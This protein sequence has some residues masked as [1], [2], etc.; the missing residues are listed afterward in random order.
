MIDIHVHI[1]PGVDDGPATIDQSMAMAQM[2]YDEGVRQ[3]IATPHRHHALQF[4]GESNIAEAYCEFKKELSKKYPDFEISLGCEF[5]IREGYISYID[6]PMASIAMGESDYVLME[7]DRQVTLAEVLESIYEFKIRNYKPIIAHVEMY[8]ALSSIESIRVLREKGATIQ[9]T[10]SSLLGKQGKETRHQIQSWIGSGLIDFVASDGHS[11]KK[12]RPLLKQAYEDVSQHFGDA[13]AQKLFMKNQE[14]L[15][16]NESISANPISKKHNYKI[17]PS[18]NLVA[19][20]LAVAIIGSVGLGMWYHQ[21]IALAKKEEQTASHSELNQKLETDIKQKL[22]QIEKEQK[23][24]TTEKA[25][26][27]QGSQHTSESGLISI[28]GQSPKALSPEA[29]D[30]KATTNNQAET[31][32]TKESIEAHYE[33]I[34]RD[35]EYKYETELSQLVNQII[36]ADK[37]IAN[38]EKKNKIV[39][40]YLDEIV[41]LEQVVDKTVYD[42]LYDMQNKLEKLKEDVTKVQDF[43]DQY[44]ETK[45]QKKEYY[46]DKIVEAHKE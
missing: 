9:V 13:F 25:I 3:I 12:R 15:L 6:S 42:A 28:E 23:Q 46:V 4:R 18:L 8:P 43:R 45:Q 41:A 21:E 26:S 30:Q 16:R 39:N 31:L 17:K 14:S 34:L 38:Q 36:I 35:M 11:A 10:A 1:I 44:T 5:Y 29:I 32:H 2:M 22:A 40:E 37:N 20:V 33:Q 24:A 19:S 27:E 7:Y